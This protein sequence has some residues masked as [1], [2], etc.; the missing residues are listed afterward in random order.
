ML[1][2]IKE[3][4]ASSKNL[5][6]RMSI[7]QYSIDPKTFSEWLTE[8]I[9]PGN[10]LKI[11]E[12]VCKLC[13]KEYSSNSDHGGKVFSSFFIPCSNSAELFQACK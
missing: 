10:D 11:L 4:Y 3:Q 2:R 1:K 12:C 8:Q 13:P 7:Y 5:E 6:A 9:T